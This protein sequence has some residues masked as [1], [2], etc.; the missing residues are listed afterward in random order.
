AR[1][2]EVSARYVEV[3][4]GPADDV[5]LRDLAHLVNLL[6]LGRLEL[7][8]F[9]AVDV[10]LRRAAERV[11]DKQLGVLLIALCPGHPELINAH[12]VLR[13]FPLPARRRCRAEVA[14]AHFRC[15]TLA[16]VGL[17]AG[18]AVGRRTAPQDRDGEDA[19]TEDPSH[20]YFSSPERR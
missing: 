16:T 18:G 5:Q 2:A 15:L 10:V 1:A 17:L 4:R 19:E 8:G 20:R 6:T 14:E 3:V 9:P 11:E 13:R 12:L 7:A